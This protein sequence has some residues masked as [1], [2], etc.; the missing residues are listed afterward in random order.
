LVGKREKASQLWKWERGPSGMSKVSN[1]YSSD[2]YKHVIFRNESKF[3][4]FL[5]KIRLAQVPLLQNAVRPVF[6]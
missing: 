6:F 1:D 4:V 2:Y 3:Y 5:F